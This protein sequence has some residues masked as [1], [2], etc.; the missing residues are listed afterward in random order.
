MASGAIII[1]QGLALIVYVVII[2]DV[3]KPFLN[4]LP[5]ILSSRALWQVL[6]AVGTEHRFTCSDYFPLNKREEDKLPYVQFV[7]GH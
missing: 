4:S 1:Q 6:V 5:D 3:L 7:S 2:A